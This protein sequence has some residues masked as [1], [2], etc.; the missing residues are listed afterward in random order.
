MRHK[1][2]QVPRLEVKIMLLLKDKR[3]AKHYYSKYCYDYIV[4]LT[5]WS[6]DRANT[7]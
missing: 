5:T 2:N 4:N 6:P 3:S 1:G 7:H